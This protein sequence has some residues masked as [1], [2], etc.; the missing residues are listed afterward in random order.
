VTISVVKDESAKSYRH[1]EAISMRLA[2]IEGPP[3]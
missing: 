3:L 2:F 1:Q